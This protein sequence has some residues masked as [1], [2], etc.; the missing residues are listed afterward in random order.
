M[1]DTKKTRKGTPFVLY[2]DE[3]L[4]S[5]VS[6]EKD[7]FFQE[8]RPKRDCKITL[9]YG[10]AD[11]IPEN[12]IDVGH[13]EIKGTEISQRSKEFFNDGSCKAKIKKS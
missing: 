12:N 8:L 3:E 7:E 4:E 11:L 9:R 5:K 13:A 10:S 6:P 2:S 1:Q